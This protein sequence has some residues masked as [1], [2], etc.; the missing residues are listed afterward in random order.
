MLT[1]SPQHNATHVHPEA[2]AAEKAPA[3]EVSAAVE[4]AP[5][6]PREAAPAVEVPA[7]QAA[8]ATETAVKT[9]AVEPAA[10]VTE[11]PVEVP[12]TE[13]A[14]PA[15]ETAVEA[16][17][18]EAAQVTEASTAAAAQATEVSTAAAETPSTSVEQQASEEIPE[19]EPATPGG[20][21]LAVGKAALSN[22]HLPSKQ[23]ALDHGMPIA[24]SLVVIVA[25]LGI[26][27]LRCR[28]SRHTGVVKYEQ[29]KASTV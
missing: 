19:Q 20:G 12:A 22:L 23:E 16:P 27:V 28:R 4:D 1:R 13:P 18:E 15:A 10:Q 2:H 5:G 11:T 8:P 21:A 26:L 6:T 17:A 29:F 9:P 25:C 7:A 24:A 3:A 14:A